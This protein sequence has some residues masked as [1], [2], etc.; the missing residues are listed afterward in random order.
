MHLHKT[1]KKPTEKN[2]LLCGFNDDNMTFYMQYVGLLVVIVIFR[3]RS[4][5][6]VEHFMN[7]TVVPNCLKYK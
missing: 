2:I 5:C 6:G 4:I 1:V 7:N 3:T